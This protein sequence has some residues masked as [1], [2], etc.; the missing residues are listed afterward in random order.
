MDN[1]RTGGAGG[2]GSKVGARFRGRLP[3]GPYNV[4]CADPP[5]PLMRARPVFDALCALPV[6]RISADDALLYL[7]LADDQ[8]E[9]CIELAGAWGY[10]WVTL[11][12]ACPAAPGDQGALSRASVELC[13]IFK[14]GRIPKVDGKRV[15]SRRERQWID[16]PATP[17]GKPDEALLR[18]E[19]MFPEHPRLGL[20]LPEAAGWDCWE[21]GGVYARAG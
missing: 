1:S 16:A 15:G 18:I 10:R 12:F 6:D 8:I 2:I 21:P 11:G 4:L 20:F 13:G 3:D 9:R 5:W 17:A 14:R 19:R 7:W